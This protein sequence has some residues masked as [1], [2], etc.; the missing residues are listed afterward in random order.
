MIHFVSALRPLWNII[1]TG[2][3]QS[4]TIRDRGSCITSIFN[5]MD[6]GVDYKKNARKPSNKIATT[7]LRK[8]KTIHRVN[9]NQGKMDFKSMVSTLLFHALTDFQDR[10]VACK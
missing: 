3:T 8:T 9:Y 7:F 4:E 1:P 5:L 10:Y 6:T 2:I